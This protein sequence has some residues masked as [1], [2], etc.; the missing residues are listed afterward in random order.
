MRVGRPKTKP[1]V[2][3]LRF[4]ME[5]GEPLKTLGEKTTMTKQ[6]GG[7]KKRG[8]IDALVW[9]IILGGLQIAG[10]AG[11]GPRTVDRDRFDYIS[12]ISESWKRQTL[13]NLVKTR[14]MDAPVFMDVTSVIN[15]Y[16]VEAQLQAGFSWQDAPLGN[17][18]TLGGSGK[19]TDR[20]TISYIPLMGE[21][22][23]QSL[24]RPLPVAGILFLIQ[25]GYSADYVFRICVQTVNGMRNR[26]GGRIMGQDA[27]PDFIELIGLL[28]HVQQMGGLGMRVKPVGEEE[29]VVMFFRPSTDEVVT[30]EV[31]RI[32]EILGLDLDAMEFRVVYGSVAANTKEIAIL[33]RSMLQI[34]I[35][36]ASYI[37]VPESDA[38]EGR[39]FAPKKGGTETESLLPP[40][41]RVRN[42]ASKPGDAYVAVR[43]RDRW[44]WIDDRDFHSKTLFYF[45]MILFSLTERGGGQEAPVITV[46]AS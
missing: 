1:F 15:S 4:E 28:R 7:R 12:A 3:V 34:L 33:S 45:M 24:M 44:F 17:I 13:L 41:I 2:D 36:Y 29:A 42:D 19:Y 23:T 20:P 16:A 21:R 10:C 5:N 25:A 11:I 9:L 39:V 27:D 40:L 32:R 43:Y 31:K 46:P 38:A 18:Q 30:R 8:N 35:E 14:Y 37:D 26:Y 22:F 6:M